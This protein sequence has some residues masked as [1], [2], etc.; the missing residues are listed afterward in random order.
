MTILFPFGYTECNSRFRA[1]G[2][3]A[4]LTYITVLPYS[5]CGVL[6]RTLGQHPSPANLLF[7]RTFGDG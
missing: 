4:C 1:A 6:E 5:Q 7:T 2:E 3:T